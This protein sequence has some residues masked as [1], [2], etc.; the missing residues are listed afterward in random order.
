MIV[1]T[2]LW[3]Q[4]IKDIITCLLAM[5]HFLLIIVDLAI[6][7]IACMGHHLLDIVNLKAVS[8]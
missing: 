1:Y 4:I 7:G 5:V 3:I 8:A 6:L 2:L